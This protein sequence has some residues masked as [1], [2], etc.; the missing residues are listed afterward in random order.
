MDM[1]F[2]TEFLDMLL[3]FLI[4]VA[5]IWVIVDRFY[6]RKSKRRDFY[7]T[8]MLISIAI[9]FIVYFMIYVL[10][11]MKGK[12]SMGVGI[13][14]FGIFSIMRYRTDTMPVREMTYL[15]VT[16]CLSVVN[17][18]AVSMSYGELIA[19]NFIVILSV[20]LCEKKLKLDTSKLV[21]YDRIELIKPERR[22]ELMADL[23]LRTGLDVLNVEVGAIDFLRD[24]AMLRVYYKPRHQNGDKDIDNMLKIKNSMLTAFALLAMATPA[25]AQSEGGM[26]LEADAEKKITKDLSIGIGGDFR[27]RNDFATVDRWSLG[28]K[29]NYK[30]TSW[31]KA[32]AGYK[33]LNTNFREKYDLKASGAL[34]HW[35]P[36][37]WG[38]KHRFY[39]SL[40]AEQK[41]LDDIKIS[42]RERW[43]Y[44]Y[45]PETTVERWDYDDEEWEDKV[46]S[47]QNKNQLRSRF[48]IEYSPKGA[49][50]SPYGSVELYNSWSVEKLRY[51]VGTDIR[52]S[53]HHSMNVFY[54]YQKSNSTDDDS[55]PDMHYIGLGYKFKF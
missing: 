23:R 55:D 45:R 39:A 27:T 28:V 51:T 41:V 10:E 34:N 25:A 5:V 14:L 53:K 36:S 32:D 33:L 46:R 19:T 3:R 4:C 20:W 9:F 40:T 44:T 22:D 48:Q 30:L 8:F 1:L 47:A 12:T 29:A 31:L 18:L 43:Q 2:S 21:Q 37:Y 6:S 42:L 38:T 11:D 16:I 15:F 13:G 54:R 7:F 24:M 50:L 26:L 49:L 35:R 52:L 17:A